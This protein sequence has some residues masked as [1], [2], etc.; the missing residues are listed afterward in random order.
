MLNVHLSH[1]KCE[2]Q[3]LAWPLNGRHNDAN[4][5]CMLDAMNRK[6]LSLTMLA[7]VCVCV[8]TERDSVMQ[9]TFNYQLCVFVDRKLKLNGHV[10]KKIIAI[11]ELNERFRNYVLVRFGYEIYCNIKAAV[12][13]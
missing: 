4:D 12:V 1:Q 8:C 3:A 9:S 10:R 11:R 6:I 5:E 7:C 13:V 2:Q